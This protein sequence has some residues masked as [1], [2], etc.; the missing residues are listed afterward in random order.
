MREH[1][2]AGLAALA[3]SLRF[4][5]EATTESFD[6]GTAAYA[7]GDYATALRLWRPLAEQGNA[8]AQSNLGTMAVMG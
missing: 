1:I 8:L 7:Q 2:K 6:D 3:R 4:A 5:P